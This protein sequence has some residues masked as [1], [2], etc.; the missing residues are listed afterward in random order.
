MGLKCYNNAREI[1]GVKCYNNAREIVGVKCYNNALEK[2]SWE[3][4]F[5]LP[6]IKLRFHH[7]GK[8][9]GGR[10]VASR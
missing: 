6:K 8:P 5:L 10:S 3:A 4:T 7:C 2:R 1:V 9:S